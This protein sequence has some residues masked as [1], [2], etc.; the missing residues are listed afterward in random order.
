VLHCRQVLDRVSVFTLRLVAMT[1][2]Y[3]L[4]IKLA[5]P[6]GWA[7]CVCEKTSN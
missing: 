4:G 3:D 2:G 7:F 1:F 5:R 6:Y